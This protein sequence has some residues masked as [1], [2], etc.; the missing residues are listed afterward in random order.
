MLNRSHLGPNKFYFHW[1]SWLELS[2]CQVITMHYKINNIAS[3]APWLYKSCMH[4]IFCTHFTI[5]TITKIQRFIPGLDEKASHYNRRKLPWV[6]CSGETASTLGSSFCHHIT[7]Q[8]TVGKNNAK[9]HRISSQWRWDEH[10]SQGS[11]SPIIT[12][13]KYKSLKHT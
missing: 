11:F 6:L 12:F 3:Y 13:W 1:Y 10:L 9:K 5:I 7:T 4:A 8:S 2:L